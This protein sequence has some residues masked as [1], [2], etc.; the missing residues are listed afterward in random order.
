MTPRAVV[1]RPHPQP[2][3]PAPRH[4][5]KEPGTFA[6]PRLAPHARGE[7]GVRGLSPLAVLGAHHQPRRQRSARPIRRRVARPEPHLVATAGVAERAK[8]RHVHGRERRAQRRRGPRRGRRRVRRRRR[9][10]RRRR[11][12]AHGALVAGATGRRAQGE[13]GDERAALGRPRE[14]APRR[15]GRAQKSTPTSSAPPNWR[16]RPPRASSSGAS[17]AE[18]RKGSTITSTPALS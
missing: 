10:G 12:I 7:V 6:P 15:P 2:T 16:S 14:P 11:R 9:R 8:G 3:P 5:P 13:G 17:P 18:G 1:E 4:H